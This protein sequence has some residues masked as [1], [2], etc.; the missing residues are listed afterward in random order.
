MRESRPLD[1][2]L[3]FLLFFLLSESDCRAFC[4]MHDH[5]SDP[6]LPELSSDAAFAE[7]RRGPTHHLLSVFSLSL[8]GSAD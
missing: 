4:K 8:P 2:A 3:F 6:L 1:T 7:P 5:S